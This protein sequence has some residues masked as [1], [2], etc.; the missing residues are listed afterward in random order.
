MGGAP[1]HLPHVPI[2]LL[3]WAAVGEADPHPDS[4]LAVRFPSWS[5][6][7]AFWR[8]ADTVR[9]SL[10]PATGPDRQGLI[11]SGVTDVGPPS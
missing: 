9:F 5:E 10:W 11:P 7:K 8:R 1:A 2:G 3:L 6:T 4:G